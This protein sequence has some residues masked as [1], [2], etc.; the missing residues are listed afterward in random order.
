M[1]FQYGYGVQQPSNQ[2]TSM[3]AEDESTESSMIDAM[4]TKA[5]AGSLVKA[6]KIMKHEGSWKEQVLTGFEEAWD[7]LEDDDIWHRLII[8]V[9]FNA[10]ELQEDDIDAV[11]N[12]DL[13]ELAD[14]LKD[15]V[16]DAVISA[17]VDSSDDESDDNDDDDTESDNGD[18][19]DDNG[20]VTDN[21]LESESE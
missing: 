3:D 18:V 5:V 7:A 15:D 19:T 17:N 10:S 20:E 4:I 11:L 2:T 8:Q 1:A 21:E 16:I 12:H 13:K 6:I 9:A 14:E